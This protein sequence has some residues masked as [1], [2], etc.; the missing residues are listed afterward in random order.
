MIAR[1]VGKVK[2]LNR[3]TFGHAGGRGADLRKFLAAVAMCDGNGSQW[4]IRPP[5]W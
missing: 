5:L 3:D 2:T 1:G 4:T